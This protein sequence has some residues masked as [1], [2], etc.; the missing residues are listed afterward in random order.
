MKIHVFVRRK[1]KKTKKEIHKQTQNKDARTFGSGKLL[2][3]DD[4][5]IRINITEIM[6]Y[7]C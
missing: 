3:S 4:H 7:V 5:V 6:K 2:I 1:E